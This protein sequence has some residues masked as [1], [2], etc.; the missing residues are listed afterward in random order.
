[1]HA[2]AQLPIDRLAACWR[3]LYHHSPPAR[4]SAELIRR[5][6]EPHRHY[7]SER[8][9][10]HLLSEFDTVKP[11]MQQPDLVELALWAHDCIYQIGSTD[12]ERRSADWLLTHLPTAAPPEHAEQLTALI[13]ATVHIG[14]PEPQGD[15]RWLNDLDLASLALPW[16]QF[17]MDSRHLYQETLSAAPDTTP[18]TFSAG[19]QRFLGALFQREHLYWTEHF[20]TTRETQA[21]DNFR[22]LQATG[23]GLLR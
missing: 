4:L 8:H 10:L 1:M 21:R 12:N 16:T 11:H 13:M 19:Q 6:A 18:E 9:V 20:R 23:A 5:Y 7:H 2:R 14:I 17:V 3:R 15:A 22:R